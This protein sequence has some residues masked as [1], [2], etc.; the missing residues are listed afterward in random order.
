[1]SEKPNKKVC[2]VTRYN[3]TLDW[4]RYIIDS[5]DIVYIYN[6]GF[7][8]KFFERFEYE[9]N[10]EKIIIKALPNVGRIDHTLI[11]HILEHWDNLP[12]TLVCLPG[13][14]MMCRN[15]GYYLNNIIRKVNFVGS[16]FSGFYSP[17]FY[18][19]SPRFN[20][21]IDNYQCEGI[22]NRNDNPF[23]KSEYVDFQAWKKA[24]VD[25]RPMRYVAMRTMF[26]VCKENIQH[27]P[28]KVYENLLTS[29]S[30]GDNIENGHFAE[31]IWAH[32]FRQY[33]FDTKVTPQLT[34]NES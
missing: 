32:I 24:L 1:M 25:D 26:S 19:V 14:V 29:L 30:V 34:E 13:S 17:R 20:Y 23:V 16:R 11:Y 18:K 28:K 12:D 4:L 7:N 10:K 27:I 3:E 2:I 9:K 8:E 15:K 33:S 5:V 21:N 22:C 31:R 6:K